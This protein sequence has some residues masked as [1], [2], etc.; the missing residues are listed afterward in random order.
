MLEVI[1]IAP[2][3]AASLQAVD[4]SVAAMGGKS[5]P[6]P[7]GAPNDNPDTKN[8]LQAKKDRGAVRNMFFKVGEKIGV[9][10]QTRLAP[11]FLAEMD[12][13]FAYQTVVDGLIDRLEGVVQQDPDVLS[14][15][16]EAPEKMNPF[17]M[18]AKNVK[19]FRGNLSD[20]QQKES[21]VSIES[22]LKRLAIHDRE[23]QQ[24]GR[25]ALRKM[26]K[27]A[28]NEKISMEEDHQKLV[29]AR[30]AMDA[31]RH[32]EDQQKLLAA[33]DAMDAARHELK[34]TRTMENLEL[35][36]KLYEKSVHEFNEQAAKVLSYAEKLPEDKTNHQH[37]VLEF[38]EVISQTCGTMSVQIKQ[39]LQ[40]LGVQPANEIKKK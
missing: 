30:D 26:R 13:Y 21:L 20:K 36:G 12:K 38:F 7:Q 27:F 4:R 24:K 2:S 16:I 37:E 28:A 18:F 29:A 35:K 3:S 10:E 19:L 39:V 1:P 17:E 6:K 34:Q 5:D 14:T 11:E 22:L 23:A 25:W 31:A 40:E 9:V 15:G 33:R 32:E 8:V